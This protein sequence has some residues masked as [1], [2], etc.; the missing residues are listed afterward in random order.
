MRK[1]RSRCASSRSARRAA[2]CFARRYSARRRASSSAASSGSSSASS[3]ASSGK[4]DRALSSSSAAIST[5][6]SPHASRSSSSRSASRSTNATTITAMSTSA[7]SS[8]SRRSSV[9]SRSNGPSNASRSSS[10]SRTDSMRRNLAALPDA[11]ARHGHRR[12]LRIDD[13]GSLALARPPL[14]PDEERGR[15]DEEDPGDPVVQAQ[16]ADVVRRVD[17]QGLDPEAPEAVQRDVEREEPRRPDPPA[18]LDE[19]QHA[20]GREVP[21]ELVEEGRVEG[22]VAEVLHRP[23]RGID[24]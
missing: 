2:A 20:D 10:S 1:N 16:A 3:A 15:D 18:T 23:M 17:A 5:R 19:K 24:L 7:G 11:A 14:P 9:R 21:D 13:P 8:S 22:R 4:S 6:N 12:S